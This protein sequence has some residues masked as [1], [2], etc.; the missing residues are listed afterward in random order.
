M[1]RLLTVIA[2][3]RMP[4][5]RHGDLPRGI[6][7]R[8]P[9]SCAHRLRKPDR[10][11]EPLT[12]SV[13]RRPRSGRA[14][15]RASKVRRA[16]PAG[17]A[18]GL[19]RRTPDE[20]ERLP[21]DRPGSRDPGRQRLRSLFTH[22][23]VAPHPVARRE[24][25]PRRQTV[26]GRF[27]LSRLQLA[28]D[29]ERTRERCILTDFCNRPAIRAPSGLPDSR[30]TRVKLRLTANLQ[31]QPCRNPS[32]RARPGYP[33]RA[34]RDLVAPRGPGGAS[35]ECSSARYLPAAVFS[36]ARR[37]CDVA[38]DALCRGPREPTRPFGRTS[39]A[40]RQAPPLPRVSSKTRR[41]ADPRTPCLDEC[42][43]PCENG[44]RRPQDHRQPATVLPALPP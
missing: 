38:S 3:A 11:S 16:R 20:P 2:S 30:C 28:S 29:R 12:L 8:P 21:S 34:W 4:A 33:G 18:A 25:G 37:A 9:T 7:R 24:P 22:A 32:R 31:L 35:I 27:K 42:S 26:A 44:S 23:G 41:F 36:T 14:P 39:S 10:G 13:A 1:T 6:H 17:P 5:A 19:G 43:L 15:T 40:N